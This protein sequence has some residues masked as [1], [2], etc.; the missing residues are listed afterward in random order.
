MARC[1]LSFLIYLDLVI[2]P[3]EL[4]RS[5]GFFAKNTAD[6]LIITWYQLPETYA[7]ENRYTF[8]L[9]LYPDGVF[10]I[11]YNGLP[12][13]QNYDIYFARNTAWVIG[14]TP[15][16]AGPRPHHL[17]FTADLPYVGGDGGIV[18]DYYLY[19]RRYLHQLFASLAYLIIGS[20]A[21]IVLSFPIFFRLNLVRPLDS[22]L[23]GMRQVNAG[24][25]GVTTPVQYHD[26]IGF[27][28]QSFNDMAAELHALVTNLEARVAARTEELARARD[29]A[30]VANRAKSAFLATMSHELRTP[31]NGILGYAQ[32]IH[33]DPAT[34]PQQ[35]QGLNVIAQSGK[36]LLSLI[37][38]VLDL[39]KVE[40]GTIELY[41]TDFHL[42]AFLNGIAEIIRVRAERK[43]I[44]FRLELLGVRGQELEARGQELGARGQELGVRGQK[45]DFLTPDPQFL[46][47][48]YVHADERR[49]RQ[50]LL[51][52]LGN[53][54]KFTDEGGVTLRVGVR[55]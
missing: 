7:S 3:D 6:R 23:E 55:D 43:G 44:A 50:A 13:T 36:H 39:A 28:T 49:L 25:L 10:D 47:P 54:V 38:D 17:R 15:G 16:S 19:F 45:P 5:G 27:L 20:S 53:A 46:I 33:R 52:L 24:N 40:S 30:E 35:Q 21:L 41:P 31:L 37:N 42:P 29:A 2:D 4:L 14:A 51:N 32:I 22:L 48:A 8:Q 34:T 26:E 18:E 12:A 1:R 11:T 9:T